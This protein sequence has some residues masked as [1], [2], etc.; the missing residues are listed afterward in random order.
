[1]LNTNKMLLLIQ[2]DEKSSILYERCDN[3]K[4]P[5]MYLYG[6]NQTLCQLPRHTQT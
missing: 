2:T 1:M 3:N 4:K 5:K 6:E